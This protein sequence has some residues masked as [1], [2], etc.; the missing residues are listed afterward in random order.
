MDTRP[1]NAHDID[2]AARIAQVLIDTAQGVTAIMARV[3][4]PGIEECNDALRAAEM[5][6]EKVCAIVSE[7][8]PAVVLLT[9]GSSIAFGGER[10]WE[11]AD[12]WTV[13]TDYTY[14]MAPPA[15]QDTHSWGVPVERP[16]P[17]DPADDYVLLAIARGTGRRP[18]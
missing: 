7:P 12:T 5:G 10:R 18:S 8:P 17:H 11:S 15:Q 3:P 1:T 14:P 6:Q 16:R 13:T 2:K 4:T 9:N